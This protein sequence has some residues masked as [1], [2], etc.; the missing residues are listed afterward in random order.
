MRYQISCE[1]IQ[2]GSYYIFMLFVLVIYILHFMR[3][4]VTLSS[5]KRVYYTRIV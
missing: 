2:M 1:C 4:R 5:S 3:L